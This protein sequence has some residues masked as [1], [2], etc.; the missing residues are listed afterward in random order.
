MA[1]H[2]RSGGS[3]PQAAN[4]SISSLASQ[5]IAT[6]DRGLSACQI[7]RQRRS[8]VRFDGKTRLPRETFFRI[9]NRL[10]PALS[11]FPWSPAV[12]L[13]LFVH[14]VDGL[15]PGLGGPVEDTR[16]RTAHREEATRVSQGCS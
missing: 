12:H 13:A 4:R 15:E 2:Q 5:L 10:S 11:V 16:L 1:R 6:E 9:L 8:A 14:R 7:T 3:L